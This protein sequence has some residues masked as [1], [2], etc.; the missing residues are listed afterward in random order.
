M[1]LAA[2]HWRSAQPSSRSSLQGS[3]SAASRSG[4]IHDTDFDYYSRSV[5]E[6]YSA[7]IV[8]VTLPVSDAANQDPNYMSVRI[9]TEGLRFRLSD[10]KKIK[11]DAPKK[12]WLSANFRVELPGLPCEHVTQIN[13]VT[14]NQVRNY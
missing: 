11:V 8:E 7:Q 9:R 2:G 13:S 1:T 12:E 3:G 5:R 6:F 14:W 10:G 4:E